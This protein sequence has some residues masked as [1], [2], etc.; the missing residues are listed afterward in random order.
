[1]TQV[2]VISIPSGKARARGRGIVC[3]VTY[4]STFLIEEPV[5]RMIMEA[6]SSLVWRKN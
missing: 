2:F 6:V 4:P 5:L 3:V 1:M